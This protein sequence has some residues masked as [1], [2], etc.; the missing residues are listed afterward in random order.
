MH[1]DMN[2]LDLN[3]NVN[4]FNGNPATV[5]PCDGCSVWFITSHWS[6]LINLFLSKFVSKVVT[7]VFAKTKTACE[8]R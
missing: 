1:A 7:N 4:K 3:L 6:V 5:R 2:I 8:S